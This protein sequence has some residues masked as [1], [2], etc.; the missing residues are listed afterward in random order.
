[1][2]AKLYIKDIDTNGWKVSE[3][4]DGYRAQWNKEH[5]NFISRQN[6][7]YYAPEIYKKMMPNENLDGELWC[8]RGQD[9]FQ[10]MGVIRKNIPIFSEWVDR[11]KYIVYDLPDYNAP[12]EERLKK[13]KII[14]EENKIRWDKL[15]VNLPEPYKSL[16]CPIIMAKQTTID[17]HETLEKIYQDLIDEGAEGVIIKNPASYYENKRSNNMLKYKPKFDEEVKIIGYKKGKGKNIKRL[18]SFVCIPLI[19][20]DTY[21]IED[22]NKDH[23]FSLSG[24]DDN[25]RDNYI[26][27]HPIGTIITIEHSGETASGKPRFPRYIRKREDIIIKSIKNSIEKRDRIISIFKTLADHESLNKEVFKA[28]SYKKAIAGLKKITDDSD[29]T[30][31]N[32]I[33][34]NGIGKSLCEKAM[35]IINTGTC[36]AYDKIKN[37]KNESVFRDIYG[38]GIIKENELNMAG[39]KSIEDLK[40]H[41][42]KNDYLNNTQLI[43]L[44]YYDHLLKR[45]PRE[46]IVKHESILKKMLEKVDPAAELTIAG[47]YRRGCPDS[48]DIDVL[49]KS[50]KKE[51]YNLFINKL[52]SIKYII[53]DLAHGKKKYNGISQLG[54]KN[55]ARRIDIM[56]TKPSE[57]PFAIFYFTGSGE[58]NKMIRKKVKDIGLTINEYSLKDINTKKEVDHIFVEEKDIFNYLNIDYVEPSQRNI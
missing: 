42:N 1:M 41:N 18:G 37:V 5:N 6:K 48:G 25:V 19:N 49:I 9:N 30:E 53:E 38:V 8:G 33:S 16:D 10:Y 56:Y 29:L 58:F 39:F 36:Q 34:I 17:S 40:N 24:M 57:Y 23:I 2:H 52:K 44:N 51:T 28:A 54:K 43:G 7:I 35:D 4:F 20:K 13:L 32:I 12:F 55:V 27:T 22:S 14:I 50:E 15:K 26:T 31:S 45:I 3:K 47:S 11:I 46:E 21:H